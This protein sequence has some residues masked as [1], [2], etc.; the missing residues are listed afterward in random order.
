MVI[1]ASQIQWTSDVTKA[2]IACKESGD[3]NAL[4]SMKKKQVLR[5]N[6]FYKTPLNL[7][8]L[9]LKAPPSLSSP[10]SSVTW[11]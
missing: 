1:T 10:F 2:L 9:L 7:V 11:R 8:E 4:R 3:N 5:E 6:I